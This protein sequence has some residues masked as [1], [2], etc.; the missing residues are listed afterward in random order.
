LGGCSDGSIRVWSL[1]SRTEVVQWQGHTRGVQTA[2]FSPNGK[3]ILTCGSDQSVCVWDSDTKKELRRFIGLANPVTAAVFSPDG[4]RLLTS[5]GS[6]A[7]V[8]EAQTGRKITELSG[9]EGGVFF[10]VYS[11][12]GRQI[13]TGSGDGTARLWEAN[14]GRQLR[15]LDV[16]DW[17]IQGAF[18]LDDQ[19]VVISDR[20]GAAIWHLAKYPFTGGLGVGPGRQQARH[21]ASSECGFPGSYQE[22]IHRPPL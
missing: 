13:L 16:G 5:A 1:K 21:T 9:H 19:R 17:V 22:L 11:H 12:N 20:Q 15:R 2:V 8:W 18:S 14:C 10:A 7:Q 3:Q 4:R 6:S